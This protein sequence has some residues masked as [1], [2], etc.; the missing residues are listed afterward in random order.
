MDVKFTRQDR[1]VADCH[2]TSVPDSITY[3]SVVSRESVSIAFLISSLNDMYISAYN[4]R[5]AYI[6]G[7]CT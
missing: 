6:N 5:N 7:K 2:K 4:T 3:S 1:L